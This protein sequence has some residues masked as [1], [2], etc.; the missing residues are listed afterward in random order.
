MAPRIEGPPP[1]E[2]NVRLALVRFSQVVF[3]LDRDGGLLKNV[4]FLMGRLGDLRRLLFEYEVRGAADL[5]QNDDDAAAD[6]AT[7]R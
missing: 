2:E 5:L 6:G 3:R 1:R 4:P 7:E